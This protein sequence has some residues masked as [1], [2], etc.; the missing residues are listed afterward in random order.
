MEETSTDYY[1]QSVNSTLSQVY[2]EEP[3][4]IGFHYEK[5]FKSNLYMKQWNFNYPKKNQKEQF[6]LDCTILSKVPGLVKSWLAVKPLN[7][8]FIPLKYFDSLCWQVYYNA[9]FTTLLSVQDW[10]WSLK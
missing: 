2:I 4:K 3:C 7:D 8:A 1:L 10:N 6:F 9:S 5:G